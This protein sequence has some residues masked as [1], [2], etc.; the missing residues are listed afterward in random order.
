VEWH[1]DRLRDGYAQ[2]AHDVA[3]HGDRTSPRGQT[4][5]E[6]QGATIVLYNPAESLPVGI[7]RG[8][9]T[10]IAAAEALQLIG[11]VSYP[12][13]MVKVAANFDQFRDD[14]TFHG[15]YGPRVRP[16]LPVIVDRLKRDPATRQAIIVLWDPLHDLFVQDSKDYPCTIALQFVI[17][18]G[19]LHMHT[20]MRSND[21]WWGLPYDVF[22]FTQLQF[23]VANA[24]GI[25]VGW[26]WH[27]ANSLHI[28]ER[29]LA[30]LDKLTPP[31]DREHPPAA[32]IGLRHSKIT[33]SMS[34]ARLLLSG[35]RDSVAVNPG[36]SWYIETLESFVRGR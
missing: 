36:E 5:Y 22:Q 12:D 26:Y 14:G 23:T 34:V 31:D 27:H 29:N 7:N 33:E 35:I 18:G 21:V 10:A 13:L 20:F 17:R 8:L 15:A 9:N 6:V 3:T 2:I 4:T 19:E 1:I 28:Y 11:G 32:G 25:P 16:Q 30:D 24:L